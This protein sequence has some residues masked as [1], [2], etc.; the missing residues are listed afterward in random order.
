[1]PD[2]TSFIGPSSISW[3]DQRAGP[4]RIK[5]VQGVVTVDMS[6]LLPPHSH[7]YFCDA[8]TTEGEN[9]CSVDCENKLKEKRKKDSRKVLFFYVGT[10]L[11]FMVV[12]YVATM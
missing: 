6:A 12:G 8:P 2:R 4:K 1:M 11:A 7:C 5:Y 3:A 9:F 10:A